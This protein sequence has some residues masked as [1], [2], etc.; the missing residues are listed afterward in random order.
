MTNG[1]T[2]SKSRKPKDYAREHRKFRI[3]V[4][5]FKKSELKQINDNKKDETVILFTNLD[6]SEWSTEEI[7]QLYGNRWSIETGYAVLKNKLEIERVTSQKAELILQEIHSQVIVHNLAAM[8]K[9]ES[10]KQISQSD[11]Y[12]YQT[13]ISNLIQ[14]LRANLARLLNTKKGFRSLIKRL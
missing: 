8:I 9:K 13:N 2:G 1:S 3:R 12:K 7:I 5:K 11:K 6:D 14:L 10:D 4:I